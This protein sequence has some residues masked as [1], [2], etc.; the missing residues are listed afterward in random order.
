MAKTTFRVSIPK[1][2]EKLLAL[3][4]RV[5]AKHTELGEDSPLRLMKSYNWEVN[6]KNIEVCLEKHQQ[7]EALKR[8][9]EDLYRQRDLL[10]KEINETVKSSRDLLIGVYRQTPKTL[11][12]FGFDIDDTASSPKK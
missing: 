2:T 7:A 6:G 11:G 5:Y 10:L 4:T 3:A 12:E 9:M 1:N 8:Q